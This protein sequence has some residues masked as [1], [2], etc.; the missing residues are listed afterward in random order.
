LGTEE[1]LALVIVHAM[2]GKA[3]PMEEDGDFRADQAGRAGY[4]T[5]FAQS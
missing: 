3:A 5:S 1:G 4:E 2:N